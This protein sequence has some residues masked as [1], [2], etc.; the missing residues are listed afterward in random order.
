[1]ADDR[2]LGRIR[3]GDDNDLLSLNRRPIEERLLSDHRE[4][5]GGN[6][7]SIERRVQ[8]LELESER[9]ELK[10][11]HLDESDSKREAQYNV[12]WA[13]FT[14]YTVNRTKWWGIILITLT[15]LSGFSGAIWSFMSKKT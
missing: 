4:T 5:D 3:L 6:S 1:M 11:H 10:Q 8:R 13:M 12:I 9:M 2:C 15:T 14:E 7:N